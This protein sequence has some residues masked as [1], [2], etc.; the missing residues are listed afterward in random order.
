MSLPTPPIYKAALWMLLT[1]S[2]F[3]LMAVAAK[4][5]SAQINTAEILFFR[6]LIGLMIVSVIIAVTGIESVKSKSIKKHVVRN[7]FHFLGQYGWFYGIAFIPLAEV[8]ALEFTVPIWTAVVATFL[9]NEKITKIRIVAIALGFIGVLVI[10]RPTSEIIHPAAFIVLIGAM[11]YGVSH[12]LTRS[13]VKYDSPLS[14]LFYMCLVQLP[15]GFFLS[16]GE[17]VM[18]AGMT[19]FWLVVVGLTALSAHYAMSKAFFYADATVVVAMDFLRLPLIML[20]GF[21]F[22][23]ESVDILLL[24]GAFIMLLGN[25]MNLKYEHNKAGN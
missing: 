3:A 19:W 22:Y 1:L 16:L 21:Y 25:Y 2:S 24:V 18:P 8:F 4:E 13:I 10:L 15:F 9:L 5:L 20:V 17:W 23:S 6:S 11:A 7:T 14:V 12:T